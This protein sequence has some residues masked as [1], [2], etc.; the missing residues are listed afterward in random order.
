MTLHVLRI[1]T[2]KRQQKESIKGLTTDVPCTIPA[3]CLGG[4]R[5]VCTPRQQE[6]GSV[7]ICPSG[8]KLQVLRH[9]VLRLRTLP[10]ASMPLHD[11]DTVLLQSTELGWQFPLQLLST[12]RMSVTVAL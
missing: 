9:S 11:E 5:S 7:R 10:T 3:V 2:Q 4:L 8:G 6:I 12:L 1:T